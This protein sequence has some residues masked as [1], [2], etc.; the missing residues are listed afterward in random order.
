MVRQFTIK[1]V[2]DIVEDTKSLRDLCVW[3]GEGET[4]R[5]GSENS[6]SKGKFFF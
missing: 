5:G 3:K 6:F 2:L 1:M 4:V